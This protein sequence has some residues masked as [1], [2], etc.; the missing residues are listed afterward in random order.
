MRGT[1]RSWKRRW[2]TT[3]NERAAQQAHRPTG[4][5]GGLRTLDAASLRQVAAE[6]R[7]EIIKT[8]SE[9]G[10]HLGASLGVVELTIALH[11]EL[12]TP[13]DAIIWDVGHQSYAHKLL[14]GRW[15]LRL[16]PHLRRAVRAFP[17][18]ARAN[19]TSTAPATAAAR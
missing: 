15:S 13:E 11:A 1:L 18:A 7:E 12:N 6:V 2:G 4:T 16:H 5:P 19:T 10:G 9:N 3:G 14:T 8:I 17:A